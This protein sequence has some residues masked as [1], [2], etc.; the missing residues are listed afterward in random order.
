MIIGGINPLIVSWETVIILLSVFLDWTDPFTEKT[1]SDFSQLKNIV[2]KT[3]E[4][5]YFIFNKKKGGRD[6]LS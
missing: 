2:K 3:I 4:K 1:F 5:K 6:R